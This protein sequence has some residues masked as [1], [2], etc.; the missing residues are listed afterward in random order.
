MVE[1]QVELARQQAVAVAGGVVVL[2]PEELAHVDGGLGA[3]VVLDAHLVG[4]GAA[5]QAGDDAG[6]AQGAVPEG[7]AQVGGDEVGGVLLRGAA[8]AE[9]HQVLEVVGPVV[10]AVGGGGDDALDVAARQQGA[11]GHVVRPQRGGS[12]EAL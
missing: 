3:V 4:R 6:G 1:D 7:L 2:A 8:V 9:L 11:R 10:G 5:Q 12:V